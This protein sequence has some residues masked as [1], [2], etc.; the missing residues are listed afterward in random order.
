MVL[1]IIVNAELRSKKWWGKLLEEQYFILAWRNIYPI[2]NRIIRDG[3][4]DRQRFVI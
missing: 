2:V 3:D 1:K 4:A